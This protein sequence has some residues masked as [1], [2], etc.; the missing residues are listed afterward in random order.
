[1]TPGI[2]RS[3]VGTVSLSL[4]HVEQDVSVV[5]DWRLFLGSSLGERS[6]GLSKARC[7]YDC[8]YGPV[9]MH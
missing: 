5:E 1:M 7:G 3:G 9:T 6:S 8:V 4:Q 2:T